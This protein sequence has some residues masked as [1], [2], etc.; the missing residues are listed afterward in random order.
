MKNKDLLQCVKTMVACLI[1]VLAAFSAV[2]VQA[3]TVCYFN[4][5]TYIDTTKFTALTGNLSMSAWIRVSPNIFTVNPHNTSG[6]VNY[7]AGIVGQGYFGTETG[8]G[9]LANSGAN[10]PSDTSD[11]GL[12]W[13]V[14][15]NANASAANKNFASG[16][17]KGDSGTLFTGDE[18][19][20]YLLVRDTA[21][22][23]ARFY[24]DGSLVQEADFLAS[25]V[26]SPTRN[27]IIGKS[28]SIYGGCFVGYIADVA[29]WN[30]ALTAEDAALLHKVGANG[31]EGKTPYV[32]FPLDEG[33]GNSVTG[34]KNGSS[35]S[36]CIATGTLVWTND[37]TFSRSIMD[38]DF[39]VSPPPAQTVTSVAELMAGV[40]PSV[41]V[42]NLDT[43][44]ALV[45]G[46]DY[47]VAY[48]DNMLPGIGRA[49][50][51]GLGGYA[52]R[53]RAVNFD[54]SAPGI[55][56]YYNV[57]ASVTEGYGVSSIAGLGE[58]YGWSLNK[59]G[60]RYI[61]GITLK[62]SIYHVWANVGH[63]T[64]NGAGC[65]TE[66]SSEIVVESGVTWTMTGKSG[67]NTVTLN[68]LLLRPGAV[69]CYIQNTVIDAPDRSTIDG[70]IA[71]D[72]GSSFRFA[73]LDD[74]NTHA[75]TLAATVIGK[76]SV[77]TY[78]TG[79]GHLGHHPEDIR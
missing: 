68:N 31:I 74:G 72:E 62:N 19:H 16:T 34:T 26:L 1:A 12:S 10:T 59:G 73:S 3:E 14:R 41:T 56:N 37:V 2:L 57:N 55:T 49:S 64:S 6:V 78:P 23:K 28:S 25:V 44:V 51:T 39:I 60:T 29:L 76:G 63:R 22:A 4:G 5:S 24:V 38:T 40:C 7:G 50:V 69:V 77:I 46:T 32:Y 58:A 13:Q 53:R 48:S 17:Y 18:W 45:L 8:F 67:N 47:T 27:F 33:S 71:M 11:D 36:P 66:V 35:L 30:V 42:S 70:L 52:G 75:V 54:I 20:H 61:R 79:G 65:T 21:T 43:S 15:V 9:I